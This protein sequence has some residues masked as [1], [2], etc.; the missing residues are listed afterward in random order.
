MPETAFIYPQT[1]RKKERL[2]S[3]KLLQEVALKGRKINQNEIR[4]AWL[5]VKLSIHTPLQTAFSV[6]KRNFKSAV[7][8]NR[9]KRRM[10][11]AYRRNKSTF[12]P[13]LV[14]QQTQFAL[15]FVYTSK[16]IIS[17]SDI[18]VKI[19]NLL[20]KLVEDIQKNNL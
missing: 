5:P 15:L 3:R 16:E 4:L 2:C 12:F 1:F 18:E 20:S 9:I 14:N 6:S 10:R 13:L 17:Y 11:E 7:D 19:I 8:R